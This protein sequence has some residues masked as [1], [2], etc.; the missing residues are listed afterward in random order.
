MNGDTKSENAE[1]RDE[2][3]YDWHPLPQLIGN[4]IT[5]GV[6]STAVCGKWAVETEDGEVV[7]YRVIEESAD[8]GDLPRDATIRQVW[9]AYIALEEHVRIEEPAAGWDSETEP[10]R[11]SIWDGYR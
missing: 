10:V 1:N 7:V 8:D 6:E 5:N 4:A 2:K 3:T 9:D 11:E